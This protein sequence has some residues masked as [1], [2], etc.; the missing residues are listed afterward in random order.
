M[1]ARLRTRPESVQGWYEIMDGGQKDILSSGAFP[2]VY[3]VKRP[4]NRFEERAW[5]CA[6]RLGVRRLD[7]A[8]ECPWHEGQEE[9]AASSRRTPR[10]LR[11]SHFHGSRSC[12]SA[13]RHAESSE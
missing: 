1:L 3:G 6:K 11:H 9:K 10:C 5:R 4:L 13:D 8:L 7:A 12:P 2:G